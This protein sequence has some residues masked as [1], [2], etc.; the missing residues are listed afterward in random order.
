MRTVLKRCET[1]RVMRAAGRR[2]A[3]SVA[4]GRPVTVAVPVARPVAVPVR[5][6]IPARDARVALEQR[7][8]GLG[9]EG[10]G[11][12]VEHQQ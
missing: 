6:S 12:L 2:V 10:G 7:M 11:R 8:L 4:A 3:V 5:R 9:V 1:S